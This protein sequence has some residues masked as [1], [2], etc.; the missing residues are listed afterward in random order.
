MYKITKLTALLFSFL[1]ILSV[2]CF[3]AAAQKAATN[4]SATKNSSNNSTATQS[5]KAQHTKKASAKSPNDVLAAP[6]TLTGTISFIG[7]SDKEVTVTG[8]DG[9]PYDFYITPK[10]KV[11][12]S[13]QKI[14]A[15][16]LPSAER[17]EATVRFVPTARG[18]MAQDLNIS[19]S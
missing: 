3:A 15:T 9:T 18:N 2:G 8:A 1:L 4:D 17:K 16:Q 10:T 11:D 13:G 6:E 5:Q 12:L 14:G 7:N 19:A